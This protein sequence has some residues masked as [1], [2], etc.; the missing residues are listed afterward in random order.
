M[1]GG[2]LSLLSS[3]T[4]ACRSDLSLRCSAALRE[5]I[6]EHRATILAH[7]LVLE[8]NGL[9]S[10]PIN[11][12]SLA[13]KRMHQEGLPSL[14]AWARADE[15]GSQVTLDLMQGTSSA[16]G[17]LSMRAKQQ[18]EEGYEIWNSSEGV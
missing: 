6:A 9:E 14:P 13:S 1:A 16:F 3:R 4:D 2:A 15:V 10:D 18:Q 11:S 12:H 7:Q 8:R 17:L 5:L